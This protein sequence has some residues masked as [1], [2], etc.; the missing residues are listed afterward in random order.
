MSAHRDFPL[1]V[2]IGIFVLLAICIGEPYGLARGAVF[3]IS[4]QELRPF[5]YLGV[6][7][8]LASQLLGS[9]RA[10][11]AILWGIV[12]GTDLKGVLGTER[13]ITMANVVPHPESLLEHEESFFRFY[14]LLTVALWVFR[15]RGALRWVAT[16][17]LPFVA[18]SG[19]RQQPAIGLGDL[20]RNA[21]RFGCDRLPALPGTAQDDG[22]CL[23]RE[24]RGWVHVRGRLPLLRCA[25]R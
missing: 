18:D 22:V 20:A 14:L 10:F 4:L 25:D 5:V 15:K 1:S 13:M 8:L 16:A 6:T 9:R 24:S 12:V 7:Y 21:D 3:N 17:L 19:P 23:R 11:E 2:D